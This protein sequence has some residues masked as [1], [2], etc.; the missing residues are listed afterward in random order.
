MCSHNFLV[1]FRVDYDA[2]KVY[3]LVGESENTNVFLDIPEI[4]KLVELLA[5]ND[6]NIQGKHYQIE[7]MDVFHDTK[8]HLVPDQNIRT[9]GRHKYQVF[10]IN[11][12]DVRELF[13]EEEEEE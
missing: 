10:K 3:L 12:F 6:P 11:P 4:K 7:K 1:Q 9:F 8:S 5:L 13:K 2:N